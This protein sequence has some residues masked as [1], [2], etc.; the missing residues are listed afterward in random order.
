MNKQ[1]SYMKNLQAKSVLAPQDVAR[2]RAKNPEDIVKVDA[3][4]PP[5]PPPDQPP[6]D[7]E[8]IQDKAKDSKKAR[9]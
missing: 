6:S 9:G 8:A 1:I 2:E 4:E 3:V 5:L 7:E